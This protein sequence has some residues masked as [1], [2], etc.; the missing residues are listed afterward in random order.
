MGAGATKGIKPPKGVAFE[1][2]ALP[3]VGLRASQ[4]RALRTAFGEYAQGYSVELD[5][6]RAVVR[7]VVGAAAADAA[8]ALLKGGVKGAPNDATEVDMA[9][10]LGPAALTAAAELDDVLAL[11]ADACRLDETA[12][13]TLQ[14]VI[15]GVACWTK[16]VVAPPSAEETD[17]ALALLALKAAPRGLGDRRALEGALKAA[18]EFAAW[19]LALSAAASDVVVA[20]ATATAPAAGAVD[21]LARYAAPRKYRP[22]RRRE[23]SSFTVLDG[24][25]V[26]YGGVDEQDA[27]ACTSDVHVVSEFPG[28]VLCD[29]TRARRR[30]TRAR[31][32][33]PARSTAA[34]ASSFS[35]KTIATWSSVVFG[36]ESSPAPAPRLGATL[37]RAGTAKVLLFGGLTKPKDAAAAAAVVHTVEVQAG[38]SSVDP[39][40]ATASAMPC[41]VADA[42][43]APP[44]RRS[45]VVCAVLGNER[46]V[47]AFGGFDGRLRRAH[48]DVWE[49]AMDEETGGTWARLHDGVA[50][51]YVAGSMD[52]PKVPALAAFTKR[53]L[54][55]LSESDDGDRLD[56]LLSVS[57]REAPGAGAV[58][59][60]RIAA[61]IRR[62]GAARPLDIPPPEIAEPE[63][64]K[65]EPAEGEDPPPE[66]EPKKPPSRVRASL[67]W[68]YGVSCRA[69]GSCVYVGAGAVAYAAGSLAVV[70][71]KTRVEE[72]G[73]VEKL[74]LEPAA[75]D[76]EPAPP[77]AARDDDEDDDDEDVVV[78][79]EDV[80][81]PLTQEEEDEYREAGAL[82]SELAVV[83]A[84]KDVVDQ[85]VSYAHGAEVL[86][87]AAAGGICASGDSTGAVALW[88][89]GSLEV[90]ARADDVFGA[91]KPASLVAFA[92]G[93]AGA[94][95]TFAGAAAHGAAYAAAWV[96]PSAFVV[97]GEHGGFLWREAYVGDGYAAAPLLSDAKLAPQLAVATLDG[98]SGL[99]GRESFAT[100]GADGSLHVWCGRTLSKSQ[101]CHAGQA[102]LALASSKN[103]LATG[104]ADGDARVWA[105]A[106]AEP[107]DPPVDDAPDPAAPPD[108]GN[109]INGA[110]ADA[111]GPA[112]APDDEAEDAS[113]KL[114]EPTYVPEVREAPPVDL[115]D[116]PKPSVALR[117]VASL[118]GCAEPF[119]RKPF[120]L[121]TVICEPGAGAPVAA[122]AWAPEGPSLAVATEAGAVDVYAFKDGAWRK[123]AASPPGPEPLLAVDFSADGAFL[124]AATPSGVSYFAAPGADDEPAADDAGE[125]D[126][127][128]EAPKKKKA[129]P[130]EYVVKECKVAAPD[131]GAVEPPAEDE[132]EDEDE[133]APKKAKAEPPPAVRPAPSGVRV[134][135]K[136]PDGG[137][138]P[139]AHAVAAALAVK[140]TPQLLL[141]TGAGDGLLAQWGADARAGA[142]G[143]RDAMAA[144]Y[145]VDDEEAP[146]RDDDLDWESTITF[147]VDRETTRATRLGAAKRHRPFRGSVQVPRMPLDQFC[148]LLH[149]DP[150]RARLSDDAFHS[151]Y[152]YG[153]DAVLALR[154]DDDADGGRLSAKAREIVKKL[155]GGGV[156]TRLERASRGRKVLFVLLRAPVHRLAHAADQLDWIVPLCPA[157][158]ERRITRGAEG[159]KPRTLHHDPK[160]THGRG[161]YVS[162]H[163]KFVNHLA[164]WCGFSAA[165]G[166]ATTAAMYWENTI[167][168][169]ARKHS[170]ILPVFT[171]FQCCWA[172]LML[173]FWKRKE[174][175]M[176]LSWGTLGLDEAVPNRPAFRGATRPSLVDGT[177]EI[178]YPKSKRNRKGVA[179]F[180]TV[181]LLVVLVVAAASSVIWVRVS[182]QTIF[183]PNRGLYVA[184][185]ASVLNTAQIEVMNYG[186]VTI[187]TKLN[188]WENHRTDVEYMN[189]LVLKLVS[190]FFFN[191]NIP[192]LYNAREVVVGKGTCYSALELNLGVIFVSKMASN[193]ASEMA[194]PWVRARYRDARDR[195]K[196][197]AAASAAEV[198]FDLSASDDIDD[199][200]GDMTVLAIRFSFIT[201][202]ITA[203]PCLTA[204]AWF[205]NHYEGTNDLKKFL[206][207]KRREWPAVAWSVGSWLLVFQLIT[208]CAV[209]TNAACIFY[210]Y[211]V[212][213]LMV[214]LMIVVPDQPEDVE[215]QLKRQRF[216]VSK[217][218]DQTPDEMD[219]DSDDGGDDVDDDD[220]EAPLRLLAPE[221]PS[222]ALRGGAPPPPVFSEALAKREPRDAAARVFEDLKNDDGRLDGA[223]LESVLGH[224]APGRDVGPLLDDYLLQAEPHTVANFKSLLRAASALGGDDASD[225]DADDASDDGDA[226]PPPPP[227]ASPLDDPRHNAAVAAHFDALYRD[228]WRRAAADLGQIS[229]KLNDP[230]LSPKKPPP[231]EERKEADRGTARFFDPPPAP[232]ARDRSSTDAHFAAIFDGLD[233][234]D[235]DDEAVPPP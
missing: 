73:V 136:R 200:I 30:R 118:D 184:A 214:G 35:L 39:Y 183:R 173:E 145:E 201:L 68:V 159:I 31:T 104:G 44:S 216:L 102:V 97:L 125:G 75:E 196:T 192:L 64:E 217:L 202:F 152:G 203:L 107:L 209:T 29:R 63:P 230:A 37:A 175:R 17:Y 92:P 56:E 103:V 223:I 205:A 199:N 50:S 187:A 78:P 235:D 59:E 129:A 206:F 7:P 117:C 158:V 62:L 198:D 58:P 167:A 131:D 208:A 177:P 113:T 220:V 170:R 47:L 109:W 144:R 5:E 40:V 188:A 106:V 207:Y 111:I 123:V 99:P 163:G 84:S 95:L 25:Y 66:P 211:I 26:M 71:T 227:P 72:T 132:E 120:E 116:A 61:I 115:L 4:L 166:V 137:H 69:R 215:I 3:F 219:S 49:L 24:C 65:P 190:F 224:R 150:R 20:R 15:V 80:F 233:D 135:L 42:S 124:R 93:G 164:L 87:V 156:E 155:H 105:V 81:R 28:A 53:H 141:S 189:N 55:V 127:E 88:R 174:C 162:I 12:G 41:A 43:L 57:V 153:Y 23:G 91:S 147:M 231:G 6:F 149:H 130:K 160:L 234:S 172:V 151:R 13:L 143:G 48:S 186:F 154:H 121:A 213:T 82:E 179:S 33:R 98:G 182:V 134:T 176:A 226:P 60:H 46:K 139:V 229:D 101:L 45:G 51:N 14:H 1:E 228:A 114:F 169:R 79:T 74:E 85:R 210:T 148:K 197:T 204:L 22:P 138:A 108:R 10:L 112:P 96:S 100:G 76:W 110:Q 222:Y 86:C 191:Y 90:L 54:A 178:H 89:G 77:G 2:A 11:L 180:V 119:A 18:P 168:D 8:F 34:P 181:F 185:G 70:A 94:L 161:P 218:I 9:R 38:A 146:A 32:T 19:I 67:A 83:K 36:P 212:F 142:D 171:F 140:T 157:A 221:T 21:V 195:G 128:A 126:D 27:N 16:G 133:D 122:V 232:E 193:Y 165:A 225:D 52:R 194:L